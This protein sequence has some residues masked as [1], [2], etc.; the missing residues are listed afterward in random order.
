MEV[1]LRLLDSQV[2]VFYVPS[3][4]EKGEKKHTVCLLHVLV[5]RICLDDNLGFKWQTKIWEW[6]VPFYNVSQTHFRKIRE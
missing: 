5:I 4:R 6:N 3:S 2:C 1:Q